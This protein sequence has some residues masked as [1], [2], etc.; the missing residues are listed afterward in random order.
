M[1]VSSELKDLSCKGSLAEGEA[2]YFTWVMYQSSDR[3]V[4][5]DFKEKPHR[6]KNSKDA[7]PGMK[8][9]RNGRPPISSEQ[10]KG[11]LTRRDENSCYGWPLMR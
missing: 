9:N 3:V 5:R 1:E 8:Q 11:W 2:N 10:R 4:N 7:T 6:C